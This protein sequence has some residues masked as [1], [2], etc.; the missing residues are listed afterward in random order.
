MCVLVLCGR[1]KNILFKILL[2]NRFDGFG[3]QVRLY[4]ET[5]WKFLLQTYWLKGKMID[6]VFH[7][8]SKNKHLKGFG[9]ISGKSIRI[10][11]IN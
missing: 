10:R 1:E 6:F 9:I 8:E 5:N 11:A 3:Q 7:I 2:L 4:I